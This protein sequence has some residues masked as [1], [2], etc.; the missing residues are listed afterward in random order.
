MEFLEGTSLKDWIAGKPVPIADL[1]EVATQIAEG[2]RAA[3]AKGV[4]HRDIK[5]ANI[6]L[7]AGGQIKIL[8][9]GL[10]KFGAESN[11][12]RSPIGQADETV[13]TVTRRGSVMGTLAYLSPEQARGEEI[14]VR[15]DI[16]SLGVV[17]YQMAT[18]HL[19]FQGNTSRELIAAIL[20]E[21]PVKPSAL[22]PSVPSSLERVILKAIEREREAR[23]QSADELLADLNA[24]ASA[25]KKRRVRIAAVTAAGLLLAGAIAMP[26]G[27]HISHVR[28]ARNDALPRARLLAESNNVSAALGILRQAERY[29]GRDP[30]IEKMRR[31]Y[32]IPASIRTSPPGADVYIKDY[33]A[34]DAP[35]E[36]VGK[37]PIAELW[38][39]HTQTYRVRIMKDGFETVEIAV[40]F[41]DLRNIKLVP[42][43][44]AP[45]GMVLVSGEIV[46]SISSRTALP[47]Y[48]IDK[49][50]VTNRQYKEFVAAG[51]YQN[52]KFWKQPFNKDGRRLSF[53]QAMAEFKDATQRPGPAG[54]QFG[55]YPEGKE[56]FPVNGVS[57][58]EAAAYA[59]FA[60][61]SLP[62][63][64][65]WY[66]ASGAGSPFA[67]MAKLSNYSSNGPAKVGSHAGL[68]HVGTY[69]MAGNV[70]EWCWNAVGSRRY[71]LGGGWTDSG[72][73]CMN[74]ENRSPWDRSAI[75]G[76]R[77][78][79]SV[80]PIPAAALAPV[81]L[82]PEN[83]P[84]VVPVSDK[85]FRAYRA[86]FSYDRT[87][88]NSA[89]ESVEESP[90]WRKERIT[91]NAAYGSERVIA[92][93]YLPK[94]SSPP[95]Q[96]VVYCPSLVAFYFHG[97]QYMEFPFISFLLLGGRAVMYPVYKGTY[98]RGTGALWEGLNGQRDVVV[99]FSKDLGRSIDYLETRP[100][101]DAKRLAFYGFSSGGC[102]DRYLLKWI[103]ASRPAYCWRRGYHHGFRYRRSMR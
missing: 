28:W 43:G 68:S 14:D 87:P 63:T 98:E 65:H 18:G 84:G 48:W 64:H 59:E 50:E 55:T 41:V 8:D 78:I 95:F 36:F 100:D 86:M 102:G 93:L 35:W 56:D 4:V 26:L 54:W 73:T 97:D 38:V 57:W 83:H 47:D 76:F 9:F 53:E 71:I 69:D 6:F 88:L 25:G 37:S 82:T 66:Q 10:A 67:F 99:Q 7:T 3:H 75:N 42:K 45:P 77:C 23:Y 49:Y 11:A 30:E 29:L 31:I 27:L 34:V 94:N 24:I 101:I 22:N 85:V 79:R 15:T 90:Q 74:P 70:R 1:L 16:N 21:T 40:G 60:G 13:T 20:Y 58:H 61:K 19:P 81:D 44:S 32:A 92:Y 62:T 5:P 72:D 17:L 51:G 46:S 12:A 91:F 33:A 39:S 89:V 80:A 52:P 2:L 96:T 103:S